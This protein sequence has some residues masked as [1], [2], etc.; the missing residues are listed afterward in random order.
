MILI[1]EPDK[2]KEAEVRAAQ[3]APEEK[4]LP[5]VEQLRNELKQAKDKIRQLEAEN[6]GLKTK[7]DLEKRKPEAKIID[8]WNKAQ[9][10]ARGKDKLG[11]R[12]IAIRFAE[13]TG[14]I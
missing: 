1:P 10:E 8:C 4:P 14:M 11:K 5:E 13:K 3:A 12:L 2:V 6:R 9:S 7:S